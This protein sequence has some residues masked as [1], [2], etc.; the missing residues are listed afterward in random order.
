MTL[1]TIISIAITLTLIYL[2]LSI[3]TSEIQEIIANFLN[4]RAK[5]LQQSIVGLL[6]EHQEHTNLLTILF[7]DIFGTKKD[8][9]RFPITSKIYE[10]YL[11]PHLNISSD[12]VT[13]FTEISH[14]PSH[15]FAHGLISVVREVLECK[16]QEGYLQNG[17][18]AIKHEAHLQKVIN[19]IQTSPLPDKLKTDFSYL[20]KKSQ[21]QVTQTE[22]ELRTLEE[23]VQTWFDR[24][25]E[26]SSEL[27]RQKAKIIS[28][29][30]GLVLVLT[31]NV[32]TINII[33]KLSKSEVLIA[34]FNSLA[35][36]VIESNSDF[37]N[38][39]ENDS[40][41]NIKSCISNIQDRLNLAAKDID[42]LP[43]GWNLSAPFREQ[44]SPLNIPNLLNAI[45]GWSISAVAISM[46]APFWFAVLRNLMDFKSSQT[47]RADRAKA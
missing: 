36:E 3:V 7:H 45:I 17:N 43:I 26:Y 34:E 35:I 29:A 27:Y 11:T 24:S 37:S 13:K 25:M 47:E 16:N 18:T 15:Q 22:K 40:E 14:V 5:N 30:L 8:K 6:G 28:F 46:G 9:S 2:V 39:S 41:I 32:D 19:D 1:S 12:L 33:N 44:F 42:N 20:L 10:Q 31:F 23:E 38:C 4:L 21:T